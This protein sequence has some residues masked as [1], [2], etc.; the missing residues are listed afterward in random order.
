MCIPKPLEAPPAYMALYPRLWHALGYPDNRRPIVIGVDGWT[1][2]G[3]S[4]LAGWIAWQFN[5]ETIH[6]DLL[7]VPGTGRVEW[8]LDCLHKL[9]EGRRG[10]QGRRLPVLVEG[11]LL[12][13]A[14]RALSLKQTS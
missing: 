4:S 3:K 11:V 8:Q 9:F 6:L 5:M 12:L 13:D 10:A 2:K 14:L 7:M 1:G